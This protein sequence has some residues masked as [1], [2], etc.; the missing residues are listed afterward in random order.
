MN[1]ELFTRNG[2]PP[3]NVDTVVGTVKNLLIQ[4]HLKPGDLIPSENELSES[5]SIS[6]GSIR[7]A[8]KILSAFGVIEIR[9]GD[10]TYIATSI[11]KKLFDPLLFSVLVSDPD[12]NEL[13]ELRVLIECGVVDLIIKHASDAEIDRLAQACN[14]MAQQAAEGVTDLEALLATDLE[15]HRIMGEITENKL[16][17][18]VYGFMMDLFVST[19]KPGHGLGSHQRIVEALSRRDL[20][21]AIDAVRDHDETWTAL[22][23]DE[24]I[25]QARSRG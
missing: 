8:M 9:P 6:R 23:Q 20:A 5:L 24:R 13:V 4:R 3:S 11:N 10:G 1:K 7:E 15:Y 25:G 2:K 19:M 18:T 12:M 21:A 17:A 14:T 22:N 16:V